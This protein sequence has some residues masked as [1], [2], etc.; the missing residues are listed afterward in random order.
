MKKLF[1]LCA[2]CTFF[3]ALPAQ[4]YTKAVGVVAGMTN[5]ISYKQLNNHIAFQADLGIG[6]NYAPIGY[7]LAMDCWDF[8]LNPNLAYQAPI[9]SG[10]QGTL[11]GF[12]GGGLSLGEVNS[13][14]FNQ[15]VGG[16]FG[17]NA[18]AGVE[19]AFSH[20]PL[21]FGFDFRPGYG[22]YFDSSE[23]I[24]AFEWRLNVS[25]RYCL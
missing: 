5:G 15:C 9:T 11:A 20:S 6:I 24:S 23:G 10:N 13:Y 4:K 12:F 3:L 22:L 21:T 25:I 19:Y 17:I 8:R 2:L 14:L 18:I 16:V 7:G 1:T